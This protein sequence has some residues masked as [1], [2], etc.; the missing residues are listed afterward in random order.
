MRITDKL[1]YYK[2]QLSKFDT[3]K[4]SIH[5]KLESNNGQTSWLQLNKESIE[6]LRDFLNKVEKEL[7][8]G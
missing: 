6:V 2:S 8:N 7:S 1:N 3:E 4:K 5:I